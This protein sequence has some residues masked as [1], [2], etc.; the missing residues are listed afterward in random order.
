MTASMNLSTIGSAELRKLSDKEFVHGLDVMS[1]QAIDRFKRMRKLTPS[2]QQALDLFLRENPD[3]RLTAPPSEQA[4]SE[5]Q[6][7]KEATPAKA[8]AGAPSKGAP[9][10]AVSPDRGQPLAEPDGYVQLWRRLRAWWDGDEVAL[11]SA[12]PAR[13]SAGKEMVIE[14]DTAPAPSPLQIRLEI[15]QTLWGEGCSLPGGPD[16]TTDLIASAKPK[17]NMEIA[18][19]TAGLG[20]GVR[21]MAANLNV[22]VHGFDRDEE[23]AL[24]G[25]ALSAKEGVETGASIQPANINHLQDSLEPKSYHI[26]CARDLFHS[27]PD[28]RNALTVIGEALKPD[29]SLVFTDFVLKNREKENEAL[30]AWR[31]SEPLKPLPSSVEEY[32]ELLSELRYT[33][34]GFDNVSDAY[35]Q[36]IQT[37]WMNMVNHLKSGNF[38]RDYVNKL[39]EEGQ[40]WLNRSRAL[41]TGQLQLVQCHAVMQRGPKRALSDAMKI[42]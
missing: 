33:V 15:I 27:I 6:A 35:I 37:G 23:L 5:A 32:R 20:A 36:A 14:V 9:T 4:G 31:K 2:H 28:R 40:V 42:D 8:P 24:A 10:K 39:M 18:D 1:A 17:K 30:V 34:K 29:G 12:K 21:A 11:S 19:L 22:T 7:K 38:S 13:R 3:K 16:Y 41:E 26:I 25:H